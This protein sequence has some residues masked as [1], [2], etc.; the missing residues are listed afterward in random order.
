MFSQSDKQTHRQTDKKQTP[1]KISTSL[2]YATL[3]GKN[4][5]ST[6]VLYP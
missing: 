3:A 6:A 2:R 5:R 1:L 4:D